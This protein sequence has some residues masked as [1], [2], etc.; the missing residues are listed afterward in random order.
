MILE[1]TVELIK[2]IYRFHKIIPPKVT[3]IIIGLKYT[4]VE[5]A[6]LSFAPF[7]GLA[8]N[9]PSVIKRRQDFEEYQNERSLEILLQ[10]AYN[11]PSL[12]KIIGVATINAL[13]QHILEIINPYE[14]IQGDI[15]D[16]LKIKNDTKITFIGQISPLIEKVRKQTNSILIIEDNLSV[17][18]KFKEFPVKK[19][20]YDLSEGEKSADILF[21]TGSSL[22]NDTLENIIKILRRSVRKII[23]IGPSASLIP[24]VLFD[25][26]VD[27]VGGMRILDHESTI[28]I[29]QESGGTKKFKNYGVKYNIIRE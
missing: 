28:K 18:E 27:I 29:I 25:Y 15:L 14:K 5:L 24:D 12:K 20:I 4:A 8:Y 9:L 11:P 7:L 19:S 10:W 17:S 23:V 16:Y 6:A 22:I 21:C 26:G 13:S 2:Q 1:K 3:Q